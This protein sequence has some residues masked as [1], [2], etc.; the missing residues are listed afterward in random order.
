MEGEELKMTKRQI[1]P[2]FTPV[3]AEPAAV[4]PV[5]YTPTK[6]GYAI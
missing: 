1:S 5:R 6:Q 2:A 4:P 3:A